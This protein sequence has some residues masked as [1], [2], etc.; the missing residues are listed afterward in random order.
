MLFKVLILILSFTFFDYAIDQLLFGF[1]Q[2]G[3]AAELFV[4]TAI[5]APF[6]F[7]V[8]GIMTVQRTLKERLRRLSETDQLTGL[9]NR[10][11]FL[12]RAHEKLVNAS[13]TTIL[14][15]DVDHFKRINDQYGHFVGDICLRH[16]ANHLRACTRSDDIIGRIGGEEFAIIL[17]N[18]D[19]ANVGLVSSRVCQPITFD[20]AKDIDAGIESFEVTMSAGGIVALPGQ[21]LTE[22]MRYA[23]QALYAAKANGRARVVFYERGHSGTSL[24]G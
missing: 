8:M 2:R 13:S 24:A 11:A 15:V 1:T 16:V 4:T 5:A 12:T 20:A 14:M 9:F 19:V 10:H 23:D 7:F 6:G 21:D 22:L 17:T 3:L 18:A